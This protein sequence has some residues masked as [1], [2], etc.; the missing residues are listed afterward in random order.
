MTCATRV[1]PGVKSCR[2]LWKEVRPS[3]LAVF[4]AGVEKNRK[5]LVEVEVDVAGAP[6]LAM[7]K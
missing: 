4:D 1:P 3:A 2:L 7:G 5:M 6:S